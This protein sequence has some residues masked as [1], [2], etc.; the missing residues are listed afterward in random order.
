MYRVYYLAFYTKRSLGA[1]YGEYRLVNLKYK[2]P[3]RPKKPYK[4]RAGRGKS[5]G[6]SRAAPPSIGSEMGKKKGKRG[7]RGNSNTKSVRLV[8]I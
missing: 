1:I 2:L 4:S 7:K 5:K 6:L 3:T 8:F